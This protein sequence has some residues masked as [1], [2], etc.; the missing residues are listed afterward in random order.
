M[1]LIGLASLSL[2]AYGC[3]FD[4]KSS[5]VNY[6]LYLIYFRAARCF[7]GVDWNALNRANLILPQPIF[8]NT[9][10]DAVFR[11]LMFSVVYLVLGV[12][13]VITSVLAMCE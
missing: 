4:F 12:L 11:T 5:S 3:V 6:M 7:T 2:T 10:S 9:D 1:I 13:L 8:P